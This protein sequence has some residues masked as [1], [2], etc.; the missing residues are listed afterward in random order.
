MPD[1]YDI[2]GLSKQRDKQTKA[3]LN[4]F[5]YRDKIEMRECQEIVVRKNEKYHVEEKRRM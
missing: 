5:S 1:Y 4:H 3:F 2:Y